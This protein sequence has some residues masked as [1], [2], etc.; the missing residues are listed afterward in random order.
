[1]GNLAEKALAK[2][3][4]GASSDSSGEVSPL[5]DALTEA[6]DAVK[7]NDEKTF[8]SAMADAMEIDRQIRRTGFT[9]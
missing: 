8:K 6:W 1:M 5:D 2:L 9:N 7:S 4:E 3:Q